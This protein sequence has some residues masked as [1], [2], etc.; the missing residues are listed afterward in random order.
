L[1]NENTEIDTAMLIDI[2]VEHKRQQ[3]PNFDFDQGQRN[4]IMHDIGPLWI[5]AGPGTGKTEVLALRCIRHLIVDKIPAKSIIVTTFTKRAAEQLRL[6]ISKYLRIIAKKI[7]FDVN[8]S[9]LRVGTLHHLCQDILTERRYEGYRNF[10]LIDEIQQRMFIYENSILLLQATE[11]E[12]IQSE[13]DFWEYFE[14][15][16]PLNED[17]VKWK[18]SSSVLPSKRQRAKAAQRLFNSVV[19]MN[20]DLNEL[21]NRNVQFSHLVSAIEEYRRK[22][23]ESYVCDQ[24][25]IQF[26][27]LQF[28]NSRHGQ[29]FIDGD[30]DTN[31]GIQR[32]LVDEYQDTNP[33]QEEIY[34][35]IASRIGNNICVVGDDDQA[36]Y[37]FRG[38]T[39]ESMTLFG[40]RAHQR[41]QLDEPI[42]PVQIQNNYRSHPGIVNW[43]NHYIVSNREMRVRGARAPNKED[44]I[45]SSGIEGDWPA[46]ARIIP[47]IRSKKIADER[48][49]IANTTV[50]LIQGLIEELNINP[51]NIC[52]LCSSTRTDKEGKFATILSELLNDS[53][54]NVY[55]PRSKI[56]H[57]NE[58]IQLFLGVL[59]T[60]LDAGRQ[61]R[62]VISG[63]GYSS[64]ISYINECKQTF[65]G[66]S[67]TQ[68]GEPLRQYVTSSVQSIQDQ[69]DP[70]RNI[71]VM[72]YNERDTD[73]KR[74]TLR[75]ICSHIL[76]YQPFTDLAENDPISATALAEVTRLI[77]RYASMPY[78]DK[79]TRDRDI[80]HVDVEKPGQIST[81]DVRKFYQTFIDIICTEGLDEPEDEDVSIPSDCI[82]MFTIHGVKG[83]EFEV[84][85]IHSWMWRGHISPGSA[86]ILE[87]ELGTSYGY[88]SSDLP[89]QEERAVQDAI[90]KFYVGYSRAK[91]I[92][93]LVTPQKQFTRIAFGGAN[94]DGRNFSQ[95]IK[96]IHMQED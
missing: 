96:D 58:N 38:G 29:T 17:Y 66:F 50:L 60:I 25:Y 15:V 73:Q 79:P 32:I 24:S 47:R 3:N 36:L 27:F 75:E 82:P 55:N 6:R 4:S 81:Y 67:Q 41:L 13:H 48:R 18:P 51:N 53:G 34:F 63:R 11:Y 95:F 77:E 7:K 68:E 86:H 72:S 23:I 40:D 39:V 2:I 22:L 8:E 65:E 5:L 26:L 91:R 92:L 37:R 9:E 1:N 54:I 35:T 69:Y 94:E 49:D 85:I 70:N 80:L 45:A 61:T 46:V 88:G 76:N 43:L 93:I 56:Y 71:V 87:N 90:R 52:I 64:T 89:N 78:H 62:D 30:S 44:L 33:I 28:L 14:W 59:F 16:V 10:S 83:L 84:V 20:V 42:L 57:Q 19:E 74:C 31:P 21:R 12:D